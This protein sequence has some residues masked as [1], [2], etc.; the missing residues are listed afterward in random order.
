M[1]RL[2][3]LI[4]I[5][6]ITIAAQA[7]EFHNGTQ[8]ISAGMGIGSNWGL[9]NGTQT[10]AISVAYEQGMWDIDGPGVISLGAY[11][12]HKSFKY[13]YNN[14]FYW[15]NQK[16]S[17]TILGLR[18][19]FHFNMIDVD[20]LDLYAGAMLSFNIAKYKTESGYHHSEY[21]HFH[22]SNLDGSYGSNLG[23]SFYAGARYYFTDNL[24]VFGELGYG[25]SYLNLGIAFKL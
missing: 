9:H 18:S 8:V 21:A 7:Q 14:P 12:G 3:I 20:K 5:V 4:S 6:T 1:K 24:A 23:L 15:Y 22:D 2:L 11:V 19:A 25:V 17:Y 10:P 16:L 13:K